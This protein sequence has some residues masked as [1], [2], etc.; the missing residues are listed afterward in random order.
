MRQTSALSDKAAP[1]FLLE[2]DEPPLSRPLPG[3]VYAAAPVKNEI[4]PQGNTKQW[5]LRGRLMIIAL[6]ATLTAW[7]AGGAAMYMAADEENDRLFD[8]RLQDL[9]RTVISFAEHEILEI[10]NDGRKD[11]V[12]QETDATLGSRYQ[13]QIWDKKGNLLLRSHNASESRPISPLTQ[14]GFG[15]HRWEMKDYRTYSMVGPLGQFRIQVAESIEE[16]S[17]VVGTLSGYFIFFLLASVVL[18]SFMAWMLLRS[19]MRSIDESADQ[20]LSRTPDDLTKV[21]VHNPPAELVP[22]IRS[23]NNLFARIEHTLS[24]ERGFTATAAHELRTPLAALRLQAQVAARARTTEQRNEALNALLESVDRA[25]H[26]LD[27]LLALAKLD[28]LQVQQS[29]AKPINMPRLFEQLML[30][31]GPPAAA[32]DVRFKTAFNARYINGIESAVSM[33]LRNLIGNAVRYTPNGGSIKIATDEVTTG[34]LLT[35]DDSGPGIASEERER[36]FERFYRLKNGR[37][38]SADGVGLGLTIVR[39]VALAHGAII[40]LND[41]PL[42]G[43]QVAVKFP[44]A[45]DH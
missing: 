40:S 6:A 10:Q 41:S 13:Y 32:K 3:L 45:P 28:D 5:S 23:I 20:L 1:Q 24:Q 42:G 21:D 8:A 25:S 34:V 4:A 30:D 7:L 44:H 2:A 37:A 12:H 36:V 15:N 27:Q 22:M 14:L 39:S 19:A 43:L 31:I 26:L 17:T 11:K 38:V 33:M 16:R 35:I 29:S 18:V 9:A